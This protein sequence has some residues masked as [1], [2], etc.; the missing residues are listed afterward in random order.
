MHRFLFGACPLL[1]EVEV[2]ALFLRQV[3]VGEDGG[4]RDQAR[5]NVQQKGLGGGVCLDLVSANEFCFFIYV[6]LNGK[7]EQYIGLY[8]HGGLPQSGQSRRGRNEHGGQQGHFLH[9]CV[10]VE[11]PHN[12]VYKG[13]L[14]F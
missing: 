10:S 6:A 2:I 14:G 4:K 9:A 5:P 11:A 8:A 1:G 13:L 12:G 7:N 3:I